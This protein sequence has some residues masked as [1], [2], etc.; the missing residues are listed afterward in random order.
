MVSSTS[1]KEFQQFENTSIYYFYL[2]SPRT[3]GKDCMALVL[4]Y[5]LGKIGLQLALTTKKYFEGQVW[6]GDILFV[7][8]KNS[9]WAK[10][11]RNFHRWS[12]GKFGV[13]RCYFDIDFDERFSY[14]SLG[15][16][17][18]NGVQTDLDQLQAVILLVRKANI[19]LRFPQQEEGISGSFSF[20]VASLKNILFPDLG[21]P[22]SYLISEGYVALKI[23]TVTSGKSSTLNFLSAAGLLELIIRTF[24][25]L[26]ENL[27]AGFYF[28]YFSG[29]G[30]VM[31]LSKYAFIIA[32]LVSPL[33]FQAILTLKISWFDEESLE[34][35]LI[36]YISSYFSYILQIHFPSNPILPFLPFLLCLK[37]VKSKSFPIFKAYSSLALGTTIAVLSIQLLPLG[38]VLSLLVPLRIILPQFRSNLLFSLLFGLFLLFPFI[39]FISSL[40]KIEEVSGHFLYFWI[41]CTV[42]P[43]LLH[44]LESFR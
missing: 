25:S 30:Q 15:P 29:P 17:G 12:Q 37:Q 21:S 9:L 13:V 5:D 23:F 14:V 3:P 19:E 26:D 8:Y 11:F 44:F 42:K 22:T 18:L 43:I 27:H 24:T 20:S 36:P 4:N 32:S 6:G 7:L 33:L 16:Y 38:L 35:L 2:K 40:Q 41:S 39:P 34:K 31:P 1:L 28:Y 10:E